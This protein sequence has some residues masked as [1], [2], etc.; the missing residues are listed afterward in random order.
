MDLNILH[1]NDPENLEEGGFAYS[2][3][4]IFAIG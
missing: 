1:K 4:R 2:R 3:K